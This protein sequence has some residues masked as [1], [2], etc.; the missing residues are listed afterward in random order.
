MAVNKEKIAIITTVANWELYNKTKHFFPTGIR[1]F[2]IDG[3]SAFYGVKSMTF[4]MKKLKKYDLDWLVMADEDVIFENPEKI[5]NLIEY[6]DKNNYTVAGVSEADRI[7]EQSKHPYVIN[8][9]FGILNLR[10]IYKIYN[11]KEML[12]NQYAIDNEFPKQVEGF[13]RYEHPMTSLAESYYCFFLWLRRKGK[14]TKFLKI[15]RPLENDLLTT[16]VHDHTNTVL[17][18][19]TWFARFYSLDTFHKK[20]IDK[21]IKKGK[22][23]SENSKII[24]LKNHSHDIKFFFYKYFRRLRRFILE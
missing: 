6:L 20:R 19:H 5:F 2:A 14:K 7:G 10:E 3:T 16:A 17:L 18:Y 11:E 1:V 15:T 9:F 24:L 4:F 12:A 22:F 23:N 21:V 13:R 8:T